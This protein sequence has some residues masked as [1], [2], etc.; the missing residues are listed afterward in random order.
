MATEPRGA[1]PG[2]LEAVLRFA[3][4]HRGAV[5]AGA[6]VLAL[7]GGLALARL[8]IDAVPDITTVQVQINTAVEGLSPLE[9]ERRVTFPIETAMAGLPRLAGTRSLSRYGLSQVTVVFQDGTDIYFAR[10]LVN[11]RLAEARA[12]L[13]AGR[14]DPQMGPI[15]TG[16][17]EIFMWAV[18]ADSAARTPAGLP[19]STTDLRDIQDW[20]VKPQ[21]RSVPGVTEINT[22]GGYR[23]QIEIAP[24]PARLV[25]YGITLDDLQAAIEAGN[26]SAG[27]GYVDHKGEQYLVTAS[28]RVEDPAELADVVVATRDGVPI[29]VH[30]VATLGEGRE[31]RTGAATENGAEVVIGTAFMLAGENSRTVARRLAR[32]MEEVGRSLPPGVR[33]RIIYDRT[34]LVDATLRTVRTNLIEGAALVVAV[35]LLLL[36][37]FTGALVVAL[38]IPL[39][40]LLAATGMVQGRISANLLSLGAIDFGIVVDGAVVMVENILRRLARAQARLGRG[41]DLRERLHETFEA[42][43]E[44]AGPTFAGLGIIMIVY[45]PLLTL[46]GIEGRM[47][48]P[49]AQVVLLVLAGA[50]LLTFTFVPAAIAVFLRGR[51]LETESP[52]VRGLVRLYVPS[53]RWALRRRVPLLI[54]AVVVALGSLALATRLGSEFVPQLDEGDVAIHVL[55][56]PGTSLSQAIAMQHEVERALVQFPEVERVFSKIGTAEIATDPMPPSVSDLIVILKPRRAWPDPR[57]KKADLLAAMEQRLALLPGNAYEFTQPIQM[58]FNE[59]IAGVRADVAVK[60]FGDDLDTLLDTAEKIAAVMRG[61]PGAADVK[62]EQVAGLPALSVDVDRRAAAR[63]GLNVTDVQDVVRA[64]LAGREAGEVYR[65]DRRV[66]IVLRLSAE[67]RNDLAA[68][69]RLPLP[70]PDAPGAGDARVGYVPL[71]AVARLR[72]EEGPNQVGREDGKRRVVA[73]AN[74]RGRDLGGFVEELRTAVERDVPLPAGCWLSYGGQFENLIAARTRLAV[75]VPIALALILMLLFG[76]FGSLKDALL[77]FSGVPLALTGGVLAL[78]ARGMPLSITAGVGFIALSGVAVLNGVVLVSFVRRLRAGGHTVEQALLEGCPSRLRAVLMTALVASLGFVPMA[79]S[80]STGA[81]VQRPLA[82]VVIGG[83]VSSTLLTLL[84]LPALYRLAHRDS[85]RAEDV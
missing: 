45:L 15:A 74:V 66:P 79:L 9:I 82:T 54:T 28:G 50:L 85:E 36:G 71:G 51:V 12:A 34:R 59:L 52:V 78:A 20:I 53:L 11:E 44:V 7:A 83:I 4:L 39:S 10:Q 41:L 60:V 57:L 68:L 16:L 67:V 32:R 46:T 31:P 17:G 56:I 58:R 19:Y 73:Q 27:A 76:A 18:E 5:L 63:Y 25:A 47:F 21:L 38:V 30:D 29:H 14:A 6:V 70:V 62:V 22:I 75:V 13:P 61:V 40:M 43:R 24:D 33:A 8:P 26:A 64:A 77:V 81:E 35:L 2:P 72:L 3:I 55:R 1:A 84:V 48:G 42:S 23:R 65:G 69:E 37:H 49:M 80:S